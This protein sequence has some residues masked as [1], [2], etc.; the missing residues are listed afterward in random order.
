MSSF[1]PQVLEYIDVEN[2]ARHLTKFHPG[3][4]LSTGH[5]ESLVPGYINDLEWNFYDELHRYFVHHT[6][7]EMYKVMA[8]KYF[9]VNTVRWGNLPIFIQVANAKIKDGMFYQSM[10]ILGIICLHQV[11]RLTQK[12][13]DEVLLEVDWWTASHWLF[14]WLHKPFNNKLLK[15]Q[16]KQDREDNEEIRGRRR[17]LRKRKFSFLTDKPNFINSNKL[18]NNVIL[19]EMHEPFNLEL[20]AYSLGEIHRVECGVLEL[21]IRRIDA[22]KVEVWPGVCPHEGALLGKQHLCNEVA[23]CPWHGRR[24]SKV[25]L[26]DTDKKVWHFL[27]MQVEHCGTHLQVT[28]IVM[29]KEKSESCS[30]KIDCAL[31]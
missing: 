18:T 26:D 5:H 1:D 15:L 7:D 22:V 28:P 23:V 20:Q 24:F 27:T 11:M 10:T 2:I 12:T 31:V 9:S 3:M 25:T 21:L 29:A 19:P 14:K 8:G 17:D 30:T 16:K 6:Y 13:E 4:T